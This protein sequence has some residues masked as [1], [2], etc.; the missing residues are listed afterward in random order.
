[1][2]KEIDSHKDEDSVCHGWLCRWGTQDLNLVEL[3]GDEAN[4]LRLELKQQQ[5][6]EVL[7][8]VDC[9][10]RLGSCSVIDKQ[11]RKILECKQQIF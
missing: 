11:H 2:I 1:M 10:E 8:V 3:D 7:T 5:Q 4:V 6:Q 9:N